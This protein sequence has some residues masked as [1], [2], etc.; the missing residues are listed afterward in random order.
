[1]YLF[2][3]KLTIDICTQINSFFTV[4]YLHTKK[5]AKNLH[6]KLQNIVTTNIV[7]YSLMFGLLSLPLFL[8]MLFPF[9]LFLV[10]ARVRIRIWAAWT[11]FT[12]GLLLSVFLVL[13][14]FPVFIRT[15]WWTRRTGRVFLLFIK[16]RF[17]W[18]RSFSFVGLLFFFFFRFCF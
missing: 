11:S 3:L 13:L 5:S 16:I 17:R 10:F 15:W 1:M 12:F 14:L 9:P 4:K 8:L 18:W 7:L 6:W 2:H